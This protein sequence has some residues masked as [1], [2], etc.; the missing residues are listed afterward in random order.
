M[1]G[2][3][4]IFKDAVMSRTYCRE[5][6]EDGEWKKET[7][8]QVWKR[9]TDSFI[10]YYQSYIDRL[11][12]APGFDEDWRKRMS[13]GK[14]LPAGRMIWAMGS[15]T[16][17]KDGYLPMMNCG[18]IVVDD[19]IE[20]IKFLMKM[21]MLGCGMGFSLEKKYFDFLRNKFVDLR[22]RGGDG[23][24][25]WLPI[26]READ[27]GEKHL[28]LTVQDTKE[29]WVDFIGYVIEC[30][31]KMKACRFDL[32]NIRPA[33]SRIKGFGGRSGDPKILG[34]IAQRIYKIITS[35]RY[36]SVKMYYDVICSIGE[37]VISGNVRRSA[38][39][40]IGDPD[41]DEFLGLKEFRQLQLNP[42][43]CYCNNSVNVSEFKQLSEK[44]WDTY[45]GGNE[46]YGWVNMFACIYDDHSRNPDENY[47][48]PEGFNPCGEQPLASREVCCLGEVNLSR[49][50]SEDD[51]FE[52]LKMCYYFCKLSFTMMSSERRTD[53]ITEINSRIGIS[54]TGISMVTPEKREWAYNCRTRLKEWDADISFRLGLN[55]SVAL[56]TVKPGGTLPKIAGSSGPGIHRPIS[57]YQIRRVRFNKHSKVMKWLKGLGLPV[58]PQLNFDRSEDQSGTQVVSFYLKN[59][60]PHDG[61]YSDYQLTSH[62]FHD[63]LNLIAEVQEK[64]SDNAIS[65]T[66]YYKLD[67]VDSVV[68]PMLEFY[69]DKLKVFSGLPYSEHNFPQAPEE[70]IT[71]EQYDKFVEEHPVLGY[72]MCNECD[73]PDELPED[74]GQ[75][76]SKGLCSDR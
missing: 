46:A 30:A 28:A 23:T 39:I 10:L 11:D 69:F 59:E 70:P 42:W 15:E 31:V 34:I 60:A 54:L 73:D 5:Y 35:E 38:L 16:I 53:D 71:K 66:V 75:C 20:P 61:F 36:S 52:S 76:D 64:W 63:M 67:S 24:R 14:A 68:R 50:E 40:A 4:E 65:V 49:A 21:L 19:P 43:R 7:P 57:E 33:G 26:C 74:F 27:V 47:V 8:D 22:Y 37:L 62:G 18:F 41:D 3:N 44:Y 45:K 48:P 6:L 17:K 56:T 51:L 12:L 32:W 25:N 9:V 1:L 13:L 58:E 2:H 29:G 55:P 72:K